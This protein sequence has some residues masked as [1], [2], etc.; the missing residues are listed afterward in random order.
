[1]T[2]LYYTLAL[3]NPGSCDWKAHTLEGCWSTSSCSVIPKAPT[4]SVR[5]QRN[6]PCRCA[7]PIVS[8]SAVKRVSFSDATEVNI[9]PAMVGDELS[10]CFYSSADMQRFRVFAQ[11]HREKQLLKGI[12]QRMTQ[13]STSSC[14]NGWS[15]LLMD[16]LVQTMSS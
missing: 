15:N 7:M 4:E 16:D 5:P 13:P 11:Y 8:S 2:R 10:Q 12:T 3:S 14:H 9:I 1:M 6:N